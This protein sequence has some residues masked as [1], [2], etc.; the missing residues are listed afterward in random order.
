MCGDGFASPKSCSS[1]SGERLRLE[2][3]ALN[4]GRAS[5]IWKSAYGKSETF[6]TSGG[7]AAED[8]FQGFVETNGFL[9]WFINANQLCFCYTFA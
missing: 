8:W 3:T 1:D 5:Q 2:P 6:R 9:A 7:T 4:R